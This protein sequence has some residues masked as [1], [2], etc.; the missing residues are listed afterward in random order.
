MKLNPR[1]LAIASAVTVAIIWTVCSLFVLAL[2]SMMSG[3]TGHMLHAHPHTFTWILT[4]TGY[5][6]GLVAW[7]AWAALMGLLIAVVYNRVASI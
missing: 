5:L 6:V 4:L 3:M 7:C 2:P 1:A